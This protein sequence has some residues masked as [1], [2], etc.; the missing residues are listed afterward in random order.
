MG[1]PQGVQG[2][3]YMPGRVPADFGD[4]VGRAQAGVARLVTAF[5][6]AHQHHDFPGLPA[7]QHTGHLHLVA[8][9]QE[10]RRDWPGDETHDQGRH[11][12]GQGDEG[13]LA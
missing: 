7:L 3:A 8:L 13:H 5:G 4:A 6:M 1:Q 11:Q 10:H 9:R 12:Q 2:L